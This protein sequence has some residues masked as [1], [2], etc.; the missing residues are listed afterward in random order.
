MFFCDF[1]VFLGVVKLL[2]NRKKIN[3][4][5][6]ASIRGEGMESNYP[7]GIEINITL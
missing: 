1:A 7:P 6:R 2:V 4:R 3:G 5:D